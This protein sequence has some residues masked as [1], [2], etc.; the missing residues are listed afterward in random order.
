LEVCKPH[1]FTLLAIILLCNINSNIGQFGYM[2]WD[3]LIK[4]ICH[5]N[6]IFCRDIN[7]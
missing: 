7:G 2:F 1:A 6:D 3:E 4:A 5:Q